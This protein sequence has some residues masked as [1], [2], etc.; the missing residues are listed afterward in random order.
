MWKWRVGQS[1]VDFGKFWEH[2]SF[3]KTQPTP[4]STHP[5]ASPMAVAEVHLLPLSF[6]R[7]ICCSLGKYRDCLF[8]KL[9]WE[10]GGLQKNLSSYWVIVTWYHCLWPWTVWT[11]ILALSLT[12]CTTLD[13]LCLWLVLHLYNGFLETST[14]SIGFSLWLNDILHKKHLSHLELKIYWTLHTWSL[15]LSNVWYPSLAEKATQAQND[16]DIILCTKYQTSL[17]NRTR[18]FL[19]EKNLPR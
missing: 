14:Y 3:L 9:S 15:L 16:Q 18:A 13:M 11:H 17:C 19:M 8:G 7:K 10:E 5:P 1:L 4:E 2:C 12:R 6:H